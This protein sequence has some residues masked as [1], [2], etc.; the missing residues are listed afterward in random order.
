MCQAQALPARTLCQQTAATPCNA[1]AA[2]PTC[3]LLGFARR[4][5][6]GCNDVIPWR[7]HQRQPGGVLPARCR[8]RRCAA[9]H[10]QHPHAHR[11]LALRAGR[12][13]GAVLAGWWASTEQHSHLR[14]V[15]HKSTCVPAQ[16]MLQRSP[17]QHQS[18]ST[19]NRL[20]AS[21]LARSRKSTRRSAA[22]RRSPCCAASC[23]PGRSSRCP[24]CCS[25]SS[26]ML[27]SKR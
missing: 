19:Q 15:V 25:S 20:T 7:R 27:G 8:H 2:V 6:L 10:P 9:P 4:A 26:I 12:R 5:V 17:K 22:A 18:P 11:Q 24:G 13:R 16:S 3:S 1:E 14:S 23:S 21:S